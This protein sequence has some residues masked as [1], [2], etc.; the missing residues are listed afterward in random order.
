VLVI[1]GAGFNIN[2]FGIIFDKTTFNCVVLNTK[3]FQDDA[4]LNK[5]SRG[6]DATLLEVSIEESFGNNLWPVLLDSQ[7]D[8]LLLM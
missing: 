8:V 7:S 5:Q 3:G 4:P 6:G 1:A 2:G